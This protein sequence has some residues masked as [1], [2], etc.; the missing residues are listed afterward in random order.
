MQQ[1]TVT[2]LYNILQK[3]LES[4]AYHAVRSILQHSFVV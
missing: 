3:F 1:K 4:W 2:F